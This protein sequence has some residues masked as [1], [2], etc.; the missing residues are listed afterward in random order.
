MHKGYVIIT[1]LDV[2][3]S[4]SSDKGFGRVSP[5]YYNVIRYRDYKFDCTYNIIIVLYL[6]LRS[7]CPGH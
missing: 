4:A 6:H 5:C 2:F 3:N 1:L 7:Q